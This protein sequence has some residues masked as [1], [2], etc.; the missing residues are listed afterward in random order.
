MKIPPFLC[1]LYLTNSRNCAHPQD[2]ISLANNSLEA[3]NLALFYSLLE[4]HTSLNVEDVNNI[5]ENF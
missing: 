2:D 1:N 4:M 5:I 3:N